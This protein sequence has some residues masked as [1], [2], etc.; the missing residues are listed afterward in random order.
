MN[1]QDAIIEYPNLYRHLSVFKDDLETRYNYDTNTQW[2]EWSFLRNF[3]LMKNSDKKIL[4]PCK[5]RI[6]KKQFVRFTYVEG[7]YYTTQDVAV[8]VKRKDVKES[9][10]YILGVLNSDVTFQW[11]KRM[12]VL[13][14]GVA[15]FSEKPLEMIPI[16]RID[17]ND[18]RERDIH[19]DIVPAVDEILIDNTDDFSKTDDLVSKLYCI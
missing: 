4:V 16:K 3:N 5:E 10:K 13:C 12:C 14:G 2:F 11:I 15:E 19:D 17:W 9:T 18:K 8:I 1:D 6:N 7:D